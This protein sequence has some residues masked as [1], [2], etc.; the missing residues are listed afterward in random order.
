MKINEHTR[1]SDRENTGV[2]DGFLPVGREVVYASGAA[3]FMRKDGKTASP[4]RRS[5]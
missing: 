1:L 3:Y 5:M 4:P 2:K